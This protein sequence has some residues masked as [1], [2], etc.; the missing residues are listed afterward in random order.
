MLF[1]F[2]FAACAPNDVILVCAAVDSVPTK[3]VEVI[4]VAPVI[5]PASTLI[6][7][8]N[9]MTEFAAGSILIAA[10]ES[11]VS[12]PA[13]SIS[14]VPSAVIWIF[15]AAAAAS[16]VTREKAPFVAAVST[17]VSPELPVMVITLPLIA[18][19]SMIALVMAA[20]VPRVTPSIAPESIFTLVM[21]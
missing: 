15:A 21:A 1:I 8:S 17:A 4:L 20:F 10:P 6:V 9:N 12:T 11:S 2:R 16:V 7:P 18:T 5:T 14:T 3:A 19:S 13:E